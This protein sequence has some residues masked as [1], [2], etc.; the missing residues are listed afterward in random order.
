MEAFGARCRMA[1]RA[2]HD[3]DPYNL[4]MRQT[5]LRLAI[6][7]HASELELIERAAHRSGASTSD[8]VRDAALRAARGAV[9]EAQA[10]PVAVPQGD[11][12]SEPPSRRSL[13]RSIPRAEVPLPEAVRQLS[14]HLGR[15][16]L[17]I[18]VGATATD[19]DAWKAETASPLLEQERRLREAHKVWQ[20]VV[21][22]ESAETTRAWWMG[23]KDALDD[24]S[25]VEVITLD[26]GP[27]VMAVA[28]K[29]AE[30]G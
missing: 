25:P 30:S 9:R 18:T 22:V 6:V 29:Y 10:E 5:P 15:Q 26:K 7:V 23:M 13:R 14:E 20:L 2:A 4:A 17:A 3:P 21:S 12:S 28:R 1:A 8:F 16:L 19:V 27:D 11:D 24:L